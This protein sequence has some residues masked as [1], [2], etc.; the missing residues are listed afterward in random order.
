MS[1]AALT[2]LVVADN[3]DPVSSILSGDWAAVSGWGLFLMLAMLIVVGSF[4]EVWVPGNRY[5]RLEETSER[6]G[7]TIS[8]LSTALQEQVR[9]NEVTKHFFEDVAPKRRDTAT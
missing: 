3:S 9:A 8:T 5:R 7:E 2:L 4:R 6:Q 1:S